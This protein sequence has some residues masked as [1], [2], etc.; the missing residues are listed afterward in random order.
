MKKSNKI[1]WMLIFFSAAS[2]MADTWMENSR[3]IWVPGNELVWLAESWLLAHD[4]MHL[5]MFKQ[6]LTLPPDS[7][8]LH[9]VE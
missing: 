4:I 6:A 5:S 9:S 2:W 7:A 8:R 1:K 3:N